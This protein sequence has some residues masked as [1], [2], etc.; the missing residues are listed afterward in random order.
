MTLD[1][2]TI[3]IVTTALTLA[4]A[5]MRAAQSAKE[6]VWKKEIQK[7]SEHEEMSIKESEYERE[8]A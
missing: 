7:E 3:L 5:V 2:A 8:R 6:R 4:E 1:K